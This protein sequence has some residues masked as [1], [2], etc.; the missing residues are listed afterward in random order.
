MTIKCLKCKLKIPENEIIKSFSNGKVI[1]KNCPYCAN[2]FIRP[3]DTPDEFQKLYETVYIENKCLLD[4]SNGELSIKVKNKKLV[5]NKN[6]IL[7]KS[8]TNKTIKIPKYKIKKIFSVLNEDEKEINLVLLNNNQL[9]L[10]NFKDYIFIDNEQ[11]LNIEYLIKSYLKNIANWTPFKNENYKPLYTH[12]SYCLAFINSTDL[13]NTGYNCGKCGY[14][15]SLFDEYFKTTKSYLLNN[16][17]AESPLIALSRKIIIYFSND[18]K[19]VLIES[20]YVK[21][22]LEE[23]SVIID[24]GPFYDDKT[25]IQKTHIKTMYAETGCGHIYLE[26]EFYTSRIY[27][28]E[29]INTS[30]AEII[31]YFLLEYL[32]N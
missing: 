5:I 24:R 23:D 21:I 27:L 22:K 11:I 29:E 14:S 8:T 20:K 31:N 19:T 15:Y 32:K 25:E 2:S 13:T 6:T 16:A 9:T 3:F 18:K 1:K 12:C 7:H 30:Q 10:I 26:F 28:D 17:Y 4:Y